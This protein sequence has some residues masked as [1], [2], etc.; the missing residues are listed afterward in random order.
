[1]NITK[2]LNGM[3]EIIKEETYLDQIRKLVSVGK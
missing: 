2:A 1:M 3:R